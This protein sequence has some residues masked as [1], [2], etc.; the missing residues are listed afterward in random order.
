MG[1]TLRPYFFDCVMPEMALNDVCVL[2][3]KRLLNSIEAE[4]EIALPTG[5]V[6][7]FA[8][9]LAVLLL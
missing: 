5:V 8:L 2:L 4:V 6:I 9:M 7:E 1:T 3:A